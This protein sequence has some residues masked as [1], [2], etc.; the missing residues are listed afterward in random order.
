MKQLLILGGFFVVAAFFSLQAT[1]AEDLCSANLQSLQDQK[2][3]TAETYPDVK[4]LVE[5]TITDAKAAQ[6]QGDTEK[7]I[8]LTRKALT[9]LRTYNN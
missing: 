3:S 6:A 1:A 8:T 4:V 7:C 5:R 9:K 2:V